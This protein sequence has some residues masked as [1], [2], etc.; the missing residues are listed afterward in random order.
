MTRTTKGRIQ[1]KN[2]S[3]S[4]QTIMAEPVMKEVISSLERL[5][6]K[7]LWKS[8]DMKTD[9]F[10]TFEIRNFYWRLH[11]NLYVLFV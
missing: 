4:R 8:R 7:N 11:A 10:K 5:I 1:I 9:G 6:L 3:V 2:K